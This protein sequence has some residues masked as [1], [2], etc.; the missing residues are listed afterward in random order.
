MNLFFLFLLFHVLLFL[1]GTFT[2]GRQNN[3]K[4]QN[5]MFTIKIVRTF[6]QWKKFYLRFFLFQIS[7]GAA[8]LNEWMVTC[9]GCLIRDF[10]IY[11]AVVNEK[12]TKQEYHWLK[13]EK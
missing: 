11:D 4:P 3:F 7:P 13:E 10:K 8:I 5:K 2:K 1:K 6:F 12:A 9:R